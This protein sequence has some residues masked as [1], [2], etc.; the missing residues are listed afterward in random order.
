MKVLPPSTYLTP[1]LFLILR[2]RI[3]CGSRS[4]SRAELGRN[5]TTL[6]TWWIYLRS[7]ERPF[8]STIERQS[9]EFEIVFLKGRASNACCFAK[10]YREIEGEWGDLWRGY[11]EKREEEKDC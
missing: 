10:C 6:R 8:S 4:S 3:I 2:K 9:A 11:S 7:L 5:P 1:N